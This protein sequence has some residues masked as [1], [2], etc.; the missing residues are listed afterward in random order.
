MRNASHENGQSVLNTK[1]EL[2]KSLWDFVHDL[3]LHGGAA[4]ALHFGVLLLADGLRRETAI[5]K[6]SDWCAE[7]DARRGL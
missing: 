1:L 2:F 5:R 7:S 6:C 3:F 4:G